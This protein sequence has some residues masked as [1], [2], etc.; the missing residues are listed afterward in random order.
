MTHAPLHVAGDRAQGDGN[1][2]ATLGSDGIMEIVIRGVWS[3]A[4]ADRFFIAL[5]PLYLTCRTHHGTVRALIRVESVQIPTVA[6]HV[7]ER[8]LAMKMAGDRNAIVVAS[9]LSRLQINR[10]ASNDNFGLFT[11]A[12]TARA[13]LLG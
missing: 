9:F 3:T 12:A 5:M 4:Q 8:I 2:D 11:D 10:L 6:M 13:W 1:F 7:R